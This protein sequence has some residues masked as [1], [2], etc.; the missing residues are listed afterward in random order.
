M[1]NIIICKY[2]L[3]RYLCGLPAENIMLDGELDGHVSRWFG[4]TG[5]SM[6]AK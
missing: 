4:Y 1:T 6:H 2:M 5:G 3:C